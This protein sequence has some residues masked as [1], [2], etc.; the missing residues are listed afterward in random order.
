[1]LYRR[2]SRRRRGGGDSGCHELRSGSPVSSRG[3][4][5]L[6]ENEAIKGPLTAPRLPRCASRANSKRDAPRQQLAR[7]RRAARMGCCGSSAKGDVAAHSDDPERETS[8]FTPQKLKLLRETLS[9]PRPEKRGSACGRACKALFLITLVATAAFSGAAAAGSFDSFCLG[10]GAAAQA[11][12]QPGAHGREPRRGR[13]GPPKRRSLL[14][15]GRCGPHRR[16]YRSKAQATCRR[17]RPSSRGGCPRRS[18]RWG[19][20]RG[21]E[22]PAAPAKAAPPPRPK[23]EAKPPAAKP[24]SAPQNQARRSHRSALRTSKPA[25]SSAGSF[26]TQRGAT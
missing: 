8:A 23:P 3:R 11:G 6:A 24:A 5:E 16:G 19:L 2:T 26:A 7:R 15:S 9:P 18:G 17:S 25:G 12:Q 1:M 10:A 22:E 20:G 14:L 13:R 4:G 21:G